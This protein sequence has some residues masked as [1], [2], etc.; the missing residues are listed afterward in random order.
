[1]T[2]RSSSRKLQDHL[3]VVLAAAAADAPEA[4][5]IRSLALDEVRMIVQPTLFYRT[6]LHAI[7]RERVLYDGTGSSAS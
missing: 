2:G 7:I 5:L 1:M 6:S 3:A 4:A